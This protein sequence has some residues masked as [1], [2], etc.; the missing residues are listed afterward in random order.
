VPGA[1]IVGGDHG[2]AIGVWDAKKHDGS[3]LPR[4][5]ANRG[6]SDRRYAGCDPDEA[7][8]ASCE[9]ANE[10]I[11]VVC[12]RGEECPRHLCGGESTHRPMQRIGIIE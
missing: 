11:E 4:L 3:G 9:L 7:A 12:R 2:Y 1:A 5:G 10:L 6:E 8:L